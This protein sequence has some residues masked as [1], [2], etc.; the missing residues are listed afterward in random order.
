MSE[1]SG[2]IKALLESLLNCFEASQLTTDKHVEAQLAFNEQVS[3]DLTHLRRQMDLTQADVD[4]VQ[5]QRTDHDKQQAAVSPHQ[6]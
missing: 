6:H 5:Q 4:E 3:S 2:E 1:T